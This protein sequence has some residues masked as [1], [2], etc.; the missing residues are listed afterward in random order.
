MAKFKL[1][2]VLLVMRHRKKC[3]ED[4]KFG[5]SMNQLVWLFGPHT[6]Q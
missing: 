6:V 5:P 4:S 1:L 3:Y 2:T